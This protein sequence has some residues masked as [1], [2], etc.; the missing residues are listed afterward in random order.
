MVWRPLKPVLKIVIHLWDTLYSNEA[1]SLQLS[2]THR[3]AYIAL[4]TVQYAMFP[5]F[6]VIQDKQ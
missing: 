5:I 3:L 6:C 1:V 2:P 4:L